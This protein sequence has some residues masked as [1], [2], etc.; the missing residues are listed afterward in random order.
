[1]DRDWIKSNKQAHFSNQPQTILCL[2]LHFI[3]H[4][5]GTLPS[6]NI[7]LPCLN[8]FPN[9]PKSFKIQT[10]QTHNQHP[11][12]V[13]H[14]GRSG[15]RVRTRHRN[16][17]KPTINKFFPSHM[18][19]KLWKQDLKPDSAFQLYTLFNEKETVLLKFQQFKLQVKWKMKWSSCYGCSSDCYWGMG[20][21]PGLLPWVKGSG[22]ATAA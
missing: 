3:S 17:R 8:A 5:K 10:V 20:S 1:M 7:M 13:C 22:T 19:S 18:T 2:Y 15:Q 16:L 11:V 6:I 14:Y 21:I 12:N 9:T 4:M